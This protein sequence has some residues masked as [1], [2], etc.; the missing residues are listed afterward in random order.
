MKLELKKP[1]SFSFREKYP[2]ISKYSRWFFAVL[3]FVAF[4]AGLCDWYLNAYKG[5]WTNEEKQLYIETEFRDT[6]LKTEAF[7]NA[8]SS[9]SK[10]A[11]SYS[12]NV[13]VDNDFFRP[14]PGVTSA[15]ATGSP[16]G[17]N[18]ASSTRPVFSGQ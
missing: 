2:V 16:S 8:V 4:G 18:T 13:I 1:I 9:V 12:K 6:V 17:G 11:E 10:W 7:R 14:L 5:E 15:T 3:F